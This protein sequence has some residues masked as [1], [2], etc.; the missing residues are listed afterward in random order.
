MMEIDDDE[1]EVK[2]FSKFKNSYVEEEECP[3][4]VS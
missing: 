3:T 1:E 4:E 2:Q